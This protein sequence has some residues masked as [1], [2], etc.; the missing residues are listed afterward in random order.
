MRAAGAHCG[1]G[2]GL[3][4]L[5]AKYFLPYWPT[6]PYLQACGPLGRT[7]EA[8][9]AFVKALR[10]HEEKNGPESMQ[11]PPKRALVKAKG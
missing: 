10:I 11:V 8:E 7:A 2:R 5:L 9:E 1:G 6:I 3:R 4:T